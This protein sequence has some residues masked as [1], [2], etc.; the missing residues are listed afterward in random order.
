MKGYSLTLGGILVMVVGTFLTQWFS[1]SCSSEITQQLPLI[2]GAIV[3]WIGRV[4][5][6]DVNIF[7][8]KQG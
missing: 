5:Q 1:E 8:F 3:A 4:R 6:G 7:G 2:G